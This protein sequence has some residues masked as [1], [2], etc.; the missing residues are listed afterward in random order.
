M[1]CWAEKTGRSMPCSAPPPTLHRQPE[2]LPA[3]S[4]VTSVRHVPS[5]HS[6]AKFKIPL[7]HAECPVAP[8]PNRGHVQRQGARG[9]SILPPL[10][11]IQSPARLRA[12]APGPPT[13]ELLVTA[14]QSLPG[15]FQHVVVAG[16]GWLGTAIARELVAQGHRVTG[17][18]RN[19][20]RAAELALL[21][22]APLVL[23][24]T[25]PQAHLALPAD[26]TAIV[27]CQ[28][29]RSDTAEGYKSAYVLANQ[30]LLRAAARVPLQALV[31]TGSTGV[32][33][34]RDGSEVNEF[35]EPSPASTTAEVLVEAELALR[36]A[37]LAGIP[38]RIVRLSG[39]YGPGRWGTLQRIRAGTL[40][41]GPGD[42]A[43][44]NY[45]HQADA[46]QVVL[47]ALTRGKDGAI[48]H[49]SDAHPPQ[50]CEVVRWLAAQLEVQPGESATGTA[51]PNR[52]ISSAWT[53]QT[54]GLTLRYADFKSGFVAGLLP[55]KVV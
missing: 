9:P 27:A 24:L 45:C 51:G 54:L 3:T 22:I 35:T 55:L 34:Q 5:T 39:L 41:L 52:R 37:A 25:H 21:G 12:L 29:A 36:H 42:T 32:F 23:D 11:R 30:T 1:G 13:K 46:V 20:E 40:A 14:Q 15:P 19:P 50:R 7:L 33:G 44:M 43:Y 17:I 47:G 53:R 48:Y 49:G 4:A 10:R 6:P 26:T 38:T 28:S 18:R 16:C 2:G 31:Y 8:D